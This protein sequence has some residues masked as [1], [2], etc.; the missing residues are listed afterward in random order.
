M[1]VCTRMSRCAPH[2]CVYM[3]YYFFLFNSLSKCLMSP[4][5]VPGTELGATSGKK[6]DSVGELALWDQPAGK[7]ADLQRQPG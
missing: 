7:C 1:H 3:S 6:G 5:C 2:V 4:S